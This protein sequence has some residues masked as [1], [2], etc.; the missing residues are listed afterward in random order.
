[1]FSCNV[2][3]KRDKTDARDHVY[4][5]TLKQ[6]KASAD[7]KLVDLR[8]ACPKV[9]ECHQRV[10]HVAIV[11]RWEKPGGWTGRA[12]S[13]GVCVSVTSVIL[14]ERIPLSPSHVSITGVRPGA[15]W[16]VHGKCDWWCL[17]VRPPPPRPTRLC[18]VTIIHLLQRASD[19]GKPV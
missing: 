15:T 11:W 17:R 2:G 7:E 9:G 19:G 5:L 13:V 3:W 6:I 12:R 4:R 10:P 14:H 8:S 18:A 1:M 16:I